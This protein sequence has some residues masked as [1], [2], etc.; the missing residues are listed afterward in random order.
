MYDMSMKI[1]GLG[2]SKSLG[3]ISSRIFMDVLPTINDSMTGILSCDFSFSCF[4]IM[5]VFE[6]EGKREVID[7][8]DYLV[9]F[10]SIFLCRTGGKLT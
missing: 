6:G 2:I 9:F 4:L 7:V 8:L 1:C 3:I 10:N 5:G